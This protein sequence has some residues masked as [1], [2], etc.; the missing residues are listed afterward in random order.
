MM[1]E[2][3]KVIKKTFVE[4]I[5]SEEDACTTT[6]RCLRRTSSWPSMCSLC[7]AFGV[8]A[9][10]LSED[11]SRRHG[12]DADV[13]SEDSSGRHENWADLT[14]DADEWDG[15]RCVTP[16]LQLG[17]P[18]APCDLTPKAE[19]KGSAAAGLPRTPASGGGRTPL[20]SKASAFVPISDPMAGTRKQDLS[21]TALA[22]VPNFE[23]PAPAPTAFGSNRYKQATNSS[24]KA[25]RVPRMSTKPQNSWTID[26]MP[27]T[28]VTIGNL[29]LDLSC[30]A[31]IEVMNKKGFA[32][33][34]N[35]VHAPRDVQS[36]L[37]HAIVNF[38]TEDQAQFFVETFVGFRDWPVPSSMP[39]SIGWPQTQ[40]LTANVDL[41]RNDPLVGDDAYGRPMIFAGRQRIPFPKSAEVI[42]TGRTKRRWG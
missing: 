14:D 34:Y 8:D 4:F 26:N 30:G 19:E 13:L 12:L 2:S 27:L 5:S 33:S 25:S 32:G 20:T 36:N 39:C 15:A 22:F 1:S 31:L 42:R 28:T 18:F 29:P 41:Y 23:A 9:D 11:S 3:R 10:A 17:V 21:S 16:P 7:T 6:A 37:G 35:F 40:G 38:T 24:E